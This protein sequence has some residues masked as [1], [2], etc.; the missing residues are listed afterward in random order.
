MKSYQELTVWKKSIALVVEVYQT[1]KTFPKEEVYVLAAQMRRAA[2][3]IPSNIAEGYSRRS[4]KEYIQFT[5][6]AFSSAAELETQLL[7]AMKLGY[8]TSKGSER[9][10]SLLQ[11]VLKMLNGLLTSLKSKSNH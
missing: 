6:I 1:T 9:V 7:I 5:Q 2:I 10:G 11:E 4:R 8:S 3:S